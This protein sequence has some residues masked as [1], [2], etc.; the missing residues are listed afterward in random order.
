MARNTIEIKGI[1]VYSYHGCLAEERQIGGNY[2]V[3]VRMLTDFKQAAID[4]DLNET[5][6]YVLINKIVRE[7][8]DIPSNLIETVGYRITEH[9]KREVNNL[10]GVQI[11]IRKYAP[12]ING[13]VNYVSIRIDE[14]FV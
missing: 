2:E 9:L 13:E 11:T 1:K 3:D 10:L 7:E 14:N 5:I 12:P 4:D 6:D 8:M